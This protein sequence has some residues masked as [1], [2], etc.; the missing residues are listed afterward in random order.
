MSP[1]KQ[2]RFL[3]AQPIFEHVLLTSENIPKKVQPLQMSTLS[4]PAENWARFVIQLSTKVNLIWL[5]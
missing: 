4:D 5:A 2:Y 1:G 3:Y